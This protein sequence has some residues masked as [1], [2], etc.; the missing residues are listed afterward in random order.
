MRVELEEQVAAET[1]K[2]IDAGFVR[3]EETPDWIASIVP[4]KR[5][6]AKFAYVWTS[7][8]STKHV[9]RTIS[10]PVTEIIVDH[11]SAYEVFSF[12]DGYAGYNQ[13]KMD[14]ADQ[15]HTSFRTPIGVY[16]YKVMPFGL[17]NAGATYQRAMTKIF[18][19]LIHKIVECYVDDLVVKAMTYEEHLKNLHIVFERLRQHALKLNPLK[20]AFMVSSGKFLGFVVRHRGIEIDPSKIKAI[21]ELKPP[22]NLKQLR[23]LQGRLAY[24]RRFIANLS[25]KIQQFTRLTKKDV[26]FKWDSDCQVAF[27]RIKQYLLH[28]PA[29]K[30]QALADFLAEHPI[31]DDSPLACDFPD[32]G[33]MNVEGE[34]PS[35]EMYFDGAS[36]IRPVPGNQVP[37][38]RADALARIAKNCANPRQRGAYFHKN[39]QPLS[40]CFS[41]QELEKEKT[42]AQNEGEM[43]KETQTEVSVVQDEEDWRQPFINYLKSGILPNEKSKQGQIKKRAL[44]Y[45]FNNDTLYR[46]SYESLW[47]RCITKRGSP[48]NERGS[49]W[50][51]WSTPIWAKNATKNQTHR[52]PSSEGHRFILAATDYF[53]KWTEAVALK[54]V[55][56]TDVVKFFRNQILYR[57]GIPRRIISDNG[58][59]FKNVKIDALVNQ[60]GIDWRYS[61]AYNPRANVLAEAFNKTLIKILRKTVGKNHK[62]WHEKLHEALWAYR[63]T[64]RTPTQATPYSLVF[65][66]EAVLPLEVEIPSL[67]VALQT[68]MTINESTKLRLD[69]LDAMDEKRLIAHQSLE[70]YQAQMTRSYDKLVRV[71][72]FRRG[73]LYQAQY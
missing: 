20:F 18:D 35:W 6:M 10:L 57:Y 11:T 59:A 46:R 14:E 67:R 2:L 8:T 66:A 16:C 63:T 21:M 55:K 31:P 43:I 72:T 42:L 49:F 73:E 44:R 1:K 48:S 4:V 29:I 56:A 62:N 52:P 40:P 36:S 58:A 37:K 33:I 9:P 61:S 47:L 54:E 26:P 64:Y 50:D 69:E 5:R 70:L 28:P 7:G 24:I 60:H 17:K 12:M 45:V 38:I 53:S 27:E 23:S 32:E 65:G 3:E 51:M 34:I 30:G 13:I 71:R 39:R 19:D 22:Q 15:K 25:G 68:E 41:K